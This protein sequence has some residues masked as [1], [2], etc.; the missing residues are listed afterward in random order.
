VQ[1]VHN[2]LALLLVKAW[3][4]SSAIPHRVLAETARH[5]VLAFVQF[6]Q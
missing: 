3:L 5:P 4:S 6:L 1:P 2:R